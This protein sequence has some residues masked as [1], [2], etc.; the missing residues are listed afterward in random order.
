MCVFT[1]L[2][3]VCVGT[4]YAEDPAVPAR[5]NY[6][7]FR[8][9]EDYSFLRDPSRRTDFWD[10][11]KYM[12]LNER[13]SAYVSLGGAT[14]QHYEFVEDDNWGRGKQDKD[15]YY[16]QRYL[17]HGDM[18]FGDGTRVFAQVASNVE[19]GRAPGPRGTDKNLVDMHQMF[20]ETPFRLNGDDSLTI[21]AGR[22]EMGFGSR[23]WID[24]R[25]RPSARLS[26]ESL[27]AKLKTGSW[28]ISGFVGRPTQIVPYE[29]DDHGS[30]RESLWGLYSVRPLA[31][32]FPANIDLYYLGHERLGA[33]FNQGV[34]D[35]NRHTLGTR[36][37]GKRDQLEYN[38][39]FA[40]QTGTFGMTDIGAYALAS[41]TNYNLFAG[42]RPVT[43][44]LRADIY[45]G[46]R[47]P[48]DGHLNSFN[49]FYPKITHVSQLA[50]TGLINQRDLQPR[51]T[52]K[53]TRDVT[54]ITSSEFIWRD[55]LRD[56]IYNA[57][58]VLL[59]D[60][61]HSNKRFVGIQPE[62]DIRWQ[63]DRH[64]VLRGI[65]NYF[66]A[67]PYLRETGPGDDIRYIG[68]MATYLF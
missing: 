47:N 40:Y 45:S 42:E 51:I 37:W 27:L 6:Q 19:D 29:F 60:G 15:G 61:N 48:Q 1:A 50:Y 14:R 3:P 22:Q 16:L 9:D 38:F 62:L 66:F 49:P 4:V 43:L 55:S 65:Y 2:L 68:F 26:F 36:L 44:Q 58:N 54:I 57:G 32:P 56:G 31:L 67:G 63:V 18:H 30:D 41:E 59:R 21:R 11:V 33:R 34:G 35:E 23:R 53:A 13:G 7:V 64:L 20:I 5:P 12:P 46:D 39:E 17:L 25:E 10:P 8:Y 52:V 24:V 28:N